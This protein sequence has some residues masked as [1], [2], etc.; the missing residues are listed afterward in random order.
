MKTVHGPDAHVTKKQRNDV[1][2]RVPLL[3][4][5]GDSEASAE[6]G[7]GSEDNAEASS[8]SQAVEDGLHVK[9]IKT[10]RSGV[11]QLGSWGPVHAPPPGGHAQRQESNA[12]CR[13]AQSPGAAGSPSSL[14]LSIPPFTTSGPHRTCQPS[15]SHSA[16]PTVG[17]R[18]PAP[19]WPV[20]RVPVVSGCCLSH[21]PPGPAAAPHPLSCLCV[22]A[23]L[24]CTPFVLTICSLS[25]PL[26]PDCT[27]PKDR[28]Y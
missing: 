15:G 25:P 17:N 5:N 28:R 22:L 21:R 7:R 16:G 12:V 18:M 14:Q 27:S 8:T 23:L 1:H 13:G 9:A 11:S 20:C 3:R 24:A 10:E 26:S 6:P 19:T 2:L 4:E